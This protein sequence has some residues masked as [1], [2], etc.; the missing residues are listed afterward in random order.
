MDRVLDRAE[1]GRGEWGGAARTTSASRGY[2][3]TCTCVYFPR[4][5]VGYVNASLSV[6]QVSDFEKRSRPKTNGSE[7]LGEAVQ[8]CR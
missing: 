8:Y 1:R 7:L 3:Y 5:L 2:V 6:F 4:C